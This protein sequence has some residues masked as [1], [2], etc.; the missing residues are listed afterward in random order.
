M[1]VH[2]VNPIT[3]FVERQGVMVLDG[4]LATALEARGWNLD[5]ELWSARM[6]LESPEEIRQVHLDFLLAGADCLTTSSYQATPSGLEKRGLTDIEANELLRTSTRLAVEARELFWSDEANRQNRLLPLVAAS[7][8]PYGAYLA[9]GSEYTGN[10]DI[11][12]DALY[13]FHLG[14]WRILGESSVDLFACETIPSQREADV[15]L[16]LLRETPSLWAWMSF[17]CRDGRHLHDGSRI[18]DAARAC[19]AES[20]VAAVGVNCTSPQL[21]SDLIGEI[22]K[23]TDKPVIVYPNSGELYNAADKTWRGAREPLD[24]AESSAQWA[25]LGATCVGGCCRVG[26]QEISNTRRQLVKVR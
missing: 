16:R 20:H 7:I 17:S 14:R 21:V 11:T 24:W 4:G 1:Q 5:D 2:A 15:L 3:R 26:P 25:Q 18:V 13:E 23:A 9:D 19:D 8:G 10:Y 12:D 6:L 22:R